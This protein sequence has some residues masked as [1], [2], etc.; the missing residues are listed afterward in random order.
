LTVISTDAIPADNELD[1]MEMDLQTSAATDFVIPG[2]VEIEQRVSDDTAVVDAS[3]LIETPLCGN[4]TE[5]VTAAAGLEVRGVGLTIGRRRTLLDDVSFSARPGTLTAVIGPSGAGKSTLARL[6]AGATRPSRGRVSF[7]GHDIHKSSGLLRGRIGMVPQDDVVHHQ[8]TVEQALGYAAELRL[9]PEATKDDR[10]EA[11]T[12]VLEELEMTAHAQTRVDKLSGGQRKRASVA[13]ELLTGPSL[14]I[15]D[16]P[17]SGL[18]PALDRHVMTKLRQLADAGRAVVVVTHSLTHLDVCDQVLLLAPGGKTAFCGPPSEIGPAMGSTNWADIFIKVGADPDGVHRSFRRRTEQAAASAASASAEIDRPGELG[19]TMRVCPWRQFSTIARRQVRLIVADRG[20]FAFLALL[21]FILG[22][23]ALAVCG[24]VG[25]GIPDPLGDSPNEPGQ[26]LVLLNVGAVFMGIALTIRDLISERAIFRRE[27]AVGL[28]SGAYLLAK[29]GVYGLAAV[30][31]S[32]ILVAITICGKGAPTQGAVLLPNASVELFVDI[33]ATCVASALLGLALSALAR[34]HEQIMPLLVVAVMAQLVFSG[35]MIPVTDRLL[36]D[37]LSWVT[38]ARWGFAASAATV[39]LNSLVPG[40]LSPKDSHWA[41]TPSSWLVDMAI[42]AA[43]SV[44]CAGLVRWKIRLNSLMG[45]RYRGSAR[46]LRRLRVADSA[47]SPAGSL[48]LPAAVEV[49]STVCSA[50][51]TQPSNGA[52]VGGLDA[53]VFGATR[54]QIPRGSSMRTPRLATHPQPELSWANKSLTHLHGLTTVSHLTPAP[55]V[56]AHHPIRCHRG[57]HMNLRALPELRAVTDP[58]GPAVADDNVSLTNGQFLEAVRRAGAS[59]RRFGVS[60]GDVVGI[61]LPNTAAFVVSLFAA[62]RVGAAVTPI[63]P[64][65]RPAEVQY[66]LADAAATVVIVDTVPE[67]D[68]GGRQVVIAS[69]L[70]A[71]PAYGVLYPTHLDEDALAL[72]I[73]TSG[74]TGRPKGVMLD[75]A[76]LTAMCC[77]VIDALEISAADHSLLILPLFHVNGI[78]IGTLSPLLAGGRM[79]IAGRFSPKT[80]FSHVEQSG[81]TYFSAVPTIYTMLCGLPAEVAPDTSSVRFAICGAAPASVE[82]LEQFQSRYGIP[83]IEGYGL[84]EGTCASTINP[85]DGP[86]KAGT[87][88]LPLPGQTI[89]LVDASGE[90]VADGEAGEVVIKGPNVMRGYLNRPEETANTIVDG[91]LHT[92]DVGRFDE[93]GYL[94]LVDRAKDMIIRGGE[95]IYPREIEAVVH[96]LPQI[97][98]A[99]VV[100]RP[101]PVYGEEPVLFVSLHPGKQLEVDLI[102]EHLTESLSKYKLP[103][104]ITILDELPKNAVGKLDKRSLRQ[105]LAITD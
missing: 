78:V 39:D 11:M 62:W 94:V 42:L 90:P 21:P 5:A 75:H 56:V 15:F 33:A 16:E 31:E 46:L 74:T 52:A 100:G 61:M 40:P 47:D 81:A 69:D 66:Q 72:L 17:T 6:I 43:L 12:R 41:N 9:P 79:T 48:S 13:M 99:A 86:R 3:R 49:L 67:F 29:V 37:T 38:P 71:Q 103:V 57:A 93:D 50:E 35:G 64:S 4:E 25:F 36:L 20:H 84:S 45:H 44:L 65:L 87:V 80:F 18:D 105:R 54:R 55:S 60:R 83:I 91:W 70:T 98:D 73:Y 82:L 68:T 59:L 88:G 95:N 28:C 8:L 7:D 34:S 10:R 24:H 85:L 63:N 76:N 22:V 51:S 97:A 14:L 96:Q 102:R 23:L 30:I 26:I 101:N 77:A 19:E 2:G 58:E 89:R 104:E 92:G 27:Q 1:A 32:A 53:D